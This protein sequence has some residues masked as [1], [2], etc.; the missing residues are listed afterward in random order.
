[1][2]FNAA[3]PMESL[4]E[5]DCWELLRSASL[6]RLAVSVADEPDVFPVNFVAVDG[7]LLI[8]TSPGTK[9]AAIRV[10]SR[11]AFETDHVG[12]DEAWSVVVKGTARILD[13]RSDADAADEVAPH[14]LLPT[15]KYVYIKIEPRDVTGR[16][17]RLRPH[18]EGG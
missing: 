10:N 1:M 6:G 9:A 12:A 3:D 16:R 8:H 4:D 18:A 2:V 13:K 14:S 15:V 5:A 17:F 11:V 7:G